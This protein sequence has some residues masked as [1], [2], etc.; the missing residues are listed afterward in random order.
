MI[1]AYIPATFITHWFC[2]TGIVVTP[3][4]Y[5]HIHLHIYSITNII[6][7]RVEIGPWHITSKYN[8][9]T[10]Y[11]LL[12]Q[13]FIDIF[14]GNAHLNIDLLRHTYSDGIIFISR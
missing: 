10:Q 4:Q 11:L 9:V 1:A 3:M 6:P 2:I 14:C 7:K 5:L 13:M 8:H 12:F